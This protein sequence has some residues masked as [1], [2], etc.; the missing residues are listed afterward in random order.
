[1]LPL[2]LARMTS[3]ACKRRPVLSCWARLIPLADRHRR[4]RFL[5]SGTEPVMRNHQSGEVSLWMALATW[6]VVGLCLAAFFSGCAVADSEVSESDDAAAEEKK[7]YGD[8]Q[9]YPGPVVSV[10]DAG[11]LDVPFNPADCDP[12]ALVPNGCGVA[13]QCLEAGATGQYCGVARRVLTESP[14]VRVRGVPCTLPPS[15]HDAGTRETGFITTDSRVPA[16]DVSVS[17]ADLPDRRLSVTDAGFADVSGVSDALMMPVENPPRPIARRLRI[18]VPSDFQ[19]HWCT[20]PLWLN[21]VVYDY[22]GREIRSP[23]T[24]DR[25][26]ELDENWHG[27][28]FVD[29]RCNGAQYSAQPSDRGRTARQM[30][31]SVVSVTGSTSALANQLDT[32]VVCPKPLPVGQYGLAIALDHE[33]IGL[34]L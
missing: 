19:S 3:T 20:N 7:G 25:T 14:C 9:P 21:I 23:V 26:I 16:P 17:D 27:L 24:A 2:P 10:A 1:M 13:D 32:A 22:L 4:S 12:G 34:C 5:F 29:V 31:Y 8:N 30:G 6:A 11:R 15:S 28:I 18:A 33:L